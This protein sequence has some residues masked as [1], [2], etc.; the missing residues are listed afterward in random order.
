M[1]RITLMLLSNLCWA[2]VPALVHGQ[3]N[4][5]EQ[6]RPRPPV[7][8]EQRDG[9]RPTAER[10]PRDG[11]RPP[12]PERDLRDAPRDR[13]GQPER[14]PGPPGGPDRPDRRGEPREGP[15]PEEIE[16]RVRHLLEAAENL[17]AAGFADQAE[18]LRRQADSLRHRQA[19]GPDRP[20]EMREVHEVIRRQNERI[21]RLEQRVNELARLVERLATE[22]RGGER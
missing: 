1:W 18:Q 12:P 16:R 8:R 9:P 19:G 5:K 10:E 4:E 21:E 3:E 11:R 15:G 7:E 13:D 2:L 6:E 20:Q 17:N 22:R 14:R